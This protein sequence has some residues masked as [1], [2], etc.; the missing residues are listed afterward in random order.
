MAVLVA[1]NEVAAEDAGLPDTDELDKD[2]GDA[3]TDEVNVDAGLPDTDDVTLDA[4][5]PDTDDVTD[6][7]PV[8]VTL[9]DPEPEAVEDNDTGGVGDTD[10]VRVVSGVGVPVG[11]GGGAYTIVASKPVPSYIQL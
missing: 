6:E 9:A 7:L 2:A 10:D 11:E 1:V 3:D 4:G 8:D 5:L